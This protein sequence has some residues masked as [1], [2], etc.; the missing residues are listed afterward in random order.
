[1]PR[2]SQGRYTARRPRLVGA[3]RRLRVTGVDYTGAPEVGGV[4]SGQPIVLGGP[5]GV[6]MATDEPSPRSR[7]SAE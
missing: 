2:D 5:A 1:M 3:G 4:V 7:K 6:A